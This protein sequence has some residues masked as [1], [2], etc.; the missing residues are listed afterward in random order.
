[1]PETPLDTTT[2]YRLLCLLEQNPG[3]SQREVTRELG[4]SLGKTS[5]CIRALADRGS[6]KW[7]TSGSAATVWPTS[8]N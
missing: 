2:R 6:V 5:Y 4:I 8:K 3:A 1:M 7:S